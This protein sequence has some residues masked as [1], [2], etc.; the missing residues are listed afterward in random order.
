MKQR[1]RR[2]LTRLLDAPGPSGFEG[3]AAAVWREEAGTFAESVWTD[4]HG[5]SFAAINAGASPRVMLAGHIDE[6]ALMVHYID[7]EGYLFVKGV[8]GWDPQVLVGQRVEVLGEGEM[9]VGVIGRRAIHL[10]DREQVE[11]SVKLKELWIDIGA[12]NGAEARERVRIGDVAVVRSETVELAN[13]RMAARSIDDRVGAVVALTALRR[14]AEK[15]ASAGVIA[16]ATCQEE[17]GYISGGGARTGSF[18]VEPQVA[19]VVDVTH[20][21]DHPSVDR[22]EHGDVKLGGGPVLSRGAAVNPVVFD[23]LVT[24]ARKADIPCQ[25]QAAPGLTGTDADSIRMSRAGVATGL[26]GIPN[27][28]MHTPNQLVAAEDVENA[29]E[30][31]ATFLAGLSADDSYLPA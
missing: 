9:V 17:I 13:D 27:R 21:T 18:G 20:A 6:I 30:L 4:V 19:I 24:A 5:N 29:T 14:A 2:F 23:R 12:R 31:I 26:V 22:T 15:G 25:L 1:M 3:A 10:I 11:K 7:D 28:Y 8:G 16:V